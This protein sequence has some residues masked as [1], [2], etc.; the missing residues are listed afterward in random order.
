MIFYASLN[1][2][3]IIR[4]ALALRVNLSR[5][6]D[7]LNTDIEKIS[8]EHDY[9][10]YVLEAYEAFF[11][12]LQKELEEQNIESVEIGMTLEATGCG[13]AYTIEMTPKSFFI[14]SE[15]E[16]EECSMEDVLRNMYEPKDIIGCVVGAITR[17]HN[18]HNDQ[19]KYGVKYVSDLVDN[20]HKKRANSDSLCYI[21]GS[22][23]DR[24]D[25]SYNPIT[26]EQANVGNGRT[27]S[28]DGKKRSELKG[29]NRENNNT[30]PKKLNSR[31]Y[32]DDS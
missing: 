28:Y 22:D 31:E 25:M 8:D 12:V 27:A 10:Q 18:V 26:P 24:T 19:L 13:V 5:M 21:N 6:I 7:S 20:E 29:Y 23:Y 11:G 32:N 4:Y 9:S 16:R 17:R 1:I 15:G 30:Q 2:E 14:C 3:S